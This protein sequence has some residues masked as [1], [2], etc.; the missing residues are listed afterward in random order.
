MFSKYFNSPTGA[1]FCRY[2]KIDMAELELAPHLKRTTS[3][4]T[5]TSDVPKAKGKPAEELERL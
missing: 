4:L 5:C 1:N 2:K 3:L